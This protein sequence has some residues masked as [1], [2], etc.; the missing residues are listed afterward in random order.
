AVNLSLAANQFP[1][2]TRNASGGI[3][4][5]YVTASIAASAWVVENLSATFSPALP[6]VVGPLFVGKSWNATSNAS[7]NGSVAW[8][9]TVHVTAANGATGALA[10]AGTASA[11]ATV[12][13]ALRCDVEGTAVVR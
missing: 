10:N 9:Q 4:I 7:F 11:K 1:N 12:P 5:K 6:L 2:V 8:A 13:V 3:A